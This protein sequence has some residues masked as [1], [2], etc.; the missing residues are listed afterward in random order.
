MYLKEIYCEGVDW[1]HLTWDRDKDG[2]CEHDNEP[3]SFVTVWNSL[4]N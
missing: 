4:I 3:C 2:S 1:I